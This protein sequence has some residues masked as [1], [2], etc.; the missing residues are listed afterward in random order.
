MASTVDPIAALRQALTLPS[1]SPEQ[2]LV[3]R[4]LRDHLETV[5]PNVAILLLKNLVPNV[6]H[7]PD[8]LFKQ[9]VFE[10]VWYVVSRLPTDP[11]DQERI[12]F[13][14]DV[15]DALRDLLADHNPFY[16]KL[17]IETLGSIYPQV[18]RLCCL[19]PNMHQHWIK[20]VDA[21]TRILD[22]NLHPTSPLGVR[23]AVAKFLQRVLLVHSKGPSDPRLHNASDPHLLFIPG[24]HPFFNIAA[25]EKEGI[26][27]TEQLLLS[28]RNARQIDLV[29]AI[30]QSFGA[31]AKLRPDLVPF[32]YGV[33]LSWD[34]AQLGTETAMA[35]R[36]IYKIMRI[37]LIHFN[38]THPHGRHRGEVDDA[39]RK[40]DF[41]SQETMVRMEESRRKRALSVSADEQVPTGDLKR[42]KV[43]HDNATPALRP[44][45]A[46]DPAILRN[47][48]FSTVPSRILAQIVIESL[49]LIEDE[50]FDAAVQK[51]RTS[52][53]K[54]LGV[55]EA[56]KAESPPLAEEIEIKAEPIDPLIMDLEDEEA[57][58]EAS[59]QEANQLESVTPETH[60]S[61][62]KLPRPRKMSEKQK[63]A[64]VNSCL[65]RVQQRGEMLSPPSSN[66]VPLQERGKPTPEMWSL[67]LI[68]MITRGAYSQPEEDEE[69]EQDESEKMGDGKA[70]E[71]STKGSALEAEYRMRRMLFN[72]IVAEF[73]A[74]SHLASLW[75]NEEWHNDSVQLKASASARQ[76][77]DYWARE[78]I[79]AT[80]RKSDKDSFS[81][82]VLDLPEIPSNLFD[83]LGEIAA[84]KDRM[85]TAMAILRPVIELRIPLRDQAMSVLLHLMTHPSE[86][87]RKGAIHTIR[88]WWPD[89]E[90][91]A[92]R[93]RAYAT[94]SL[95]RLAKAGEEST[96]D[97]AMEELGPYLPPTPTLPADKNEIT[98]YV[99]SSLAL[100][101][102][103]PSFLEPLFE[104]YSKMDSTVQDA[105]HEL[106]TRPIQA[107]GP[108]AKLLGYLKSYPEGAERL[109]LRILN[110]F[111]ESGR[112]T[113][114]VFTLVKTLI[115]DRGADARFLMLIISEMDKP[116]IVKHLPKLVDTLNGT[117]EN[118][119]LVRQ[120]FT[121]IV[122]IPQLTNTNQVREAQSRLLTPKE[123]MI[124]LHDMETEVGLPK[125]KEAISVCFNMPEIFKSEV[126]ASVMQHYLD[127]KA[128]PMLFL[129]TVLQAVAT[130]KHLAAW[131]ST[132]LLS[133]LITKKVWTDRQL[134]NG[135]ILCA[136]RTEP[137][138]FD[139]LLQLPKEQL[140]DLVE[141]R[142]AM[143]PKLRDWLTKKAG[144][145]K[146]RFSGFFEVLGDDAMDQT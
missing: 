47:F 112:P 113:P 50:Q 80:A 65:Q 82:F 19:D 36:S 116:E 7:Q 111:I 55:Q 29:T 146:A 49:K 109:V 51:W 102:K 17:A 52:T 118:R 144:K 83:L 122:E 75:L 67:L 105:L 32:V 91:M 33:Y 60:V 8:S 92:S 114:S 45:R 78:I 107:M 66:V 115:A 41:K 86:P 136:E 76:N 117:A 24:N 62:F 15:V 103:D 28:F 72:Y 130:Y 21:R 73:K 93:I 134:W 142:P 123:L 40:L 90:P 34:P 135:F 22:Y 100:S 108:N 25:M 38:K 10:L 59:T 106:L 20:M 139:A 56:A 128:L 39:I 121:S 145:N 126:L 57:P 89:V 101:V 9:W 131:V 88:R 96:S 23:I 2:A 11:H 54:G 69:E 120:M 137:N 6:Q 4:N 127:A 5:S 53:A 143:K 14:L 133:R 61:T 44:F 138:S 85:P 30:V 31:L 71:K 94:T 37:T 70:V 74:R 48:D 42:L 63:V 43:S 77:F 98:Q 1:D 68:R 129:W 141:K 81:Q 35:I 140:R 104:T 119:A 46:V 99:E 95:K 132:T 110:I 27:F 58:M 84:D 13:V 3:L 26:T 18:F 16:M 12:R 97:P 64:L 87:T 125:A 124:Q 79:E